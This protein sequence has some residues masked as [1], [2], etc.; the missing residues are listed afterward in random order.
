MRGLLEVFIVRKKVKVCI[1]ELLVGKFN[2]FSKVVRGGWVFNRRFYD[3]MI[4]ILNLDFYIW[5]NLVVK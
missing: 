5:F 1:L 3:V 2:F 4:G